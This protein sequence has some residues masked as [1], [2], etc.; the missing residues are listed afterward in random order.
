MTKNDEKVS[1]AGREY[2]LHAA[3]LQLRFNEVHKLLVQEIA[4][5]QQAGIISWL[6]KSPLVVSRDIQKK[7]KTELKHFEICI[8][9]FEQTCIETIVET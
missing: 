6:T 2:F 7:L 1:K 5:L 8:R 9:I 4:P 3:K